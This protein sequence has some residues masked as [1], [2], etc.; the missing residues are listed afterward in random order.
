MKINRR[1]LLRMGGGAGV[2]IAL[3]GGFWKWSQLPPAEKG[4]EPVSKM[5]PTVQPNV[6]VAAY[7]GEVID[8]W[9][10][11]LQEP[12][13]SGNREHFVPKALQAFASMT[14]LTRFKKVWEK[15]RPMR[16]SGKKPFLQA[17]SYRSCGESLGWLSWVEDSEA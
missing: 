1:D 3:G 5:F 8:G 10:L 17:A 6:W 14:R 13:P 7:S 4:L 12:S 9:P 11:I 15:G 16:P 2:A